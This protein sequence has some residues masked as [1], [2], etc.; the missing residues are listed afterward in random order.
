MIED[1]MF[2]AYILYT[3]LH[4]TTSHHT[5]NPYNTIR[6]L[7]FFTKDAP[8][9]LKGRHVSLQNA[10]PLPQ[11][12]SQTIRSTPDINLPSS[13]SHS[14]F[15]SLIGYLVR[16]RLILRESE[17]ESESERGGESERVEKGKGR[18]GESGR[19]GNG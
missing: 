15:S 13:H 5:I 10:S 4:Y 1:K 3:T 7:T 12:P 8:A 19:D 16:P 18:R 2:W 11:K 14:H 17:S 6:P 9:S